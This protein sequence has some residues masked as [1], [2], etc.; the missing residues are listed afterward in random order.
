MDVFFLYADDII[1]YFTPN[2]QGQASDLFRLSFPT[3]AFPETAIYRR[4]LWKIPSRT[5][6]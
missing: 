6:L 5:S 1:L 4:P 3:I 2:S